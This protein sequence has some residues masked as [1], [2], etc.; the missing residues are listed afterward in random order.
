MNFQMK[1]EEEKNKL[2]ADDGGSDM[3]SSETEERNKEHVHRS[4]WKV[5]KQSVKRVFSLALYFCWSLVCR[6]CFNFVIIIMITM[7]LF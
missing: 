1:R 3:G 7:L 4:K 5:Y 6:V 2:D